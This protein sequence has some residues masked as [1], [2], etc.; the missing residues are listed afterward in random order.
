ME[1]ARRRTGSERSGGSPTETSR[2]TGTWGWGSPQRPSAHR[3]SP[4]QHQKSR[5]KIT[6]Q[7]R[8]TSIVFLVPA[9]P[10]HSTHL[11][12]YEGV[13]LLS[14]AEPSL[15]SSLQNGR[16]CFPGCMKFLGRRQGGMIIMESFFRS[17]LCRDAL[18]FSWKHHPPTIPS[19]HLSSPILPKMLRH[20][21]S[22]WTGVK[23]RPKIL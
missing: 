14:T 2:M 17:L 5:I 3:T 9:P 4:P 23:V 16:A 11:V 13:L 10:V 6:P 12:V 15:A 7:I 8:L 22:S 21:H 1:F 20:T 18:S 19:S